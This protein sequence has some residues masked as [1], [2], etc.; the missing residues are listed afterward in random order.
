MSSK[1]SINEVLTT[2][3]AK[4]SKYQVYILNN[5]TTPRDFVHQLLKDIFKHT[6]D[7]ANTIIA[8]I[9]ADGIAGVGTY[10]YEIAEQKITEVMYASHR[11]G[12][13]LD[14]TLDSIW[15]CDK[16]CN[17]VF[18]WDLLILTSQDYY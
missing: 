16:Y 6:D 3:Y 8:Q 10:F 5:D 17:G 7:A 12:F 2:G 18:K 1:L 4:P 11:A 15:N 13:N 9:E 14:I